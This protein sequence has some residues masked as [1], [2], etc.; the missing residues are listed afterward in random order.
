VNTT[1]ECLVGFGCF[2]QA[3][4]VGSRPNANHF[5]ISTGHL[6]GMTVIHF[7]QFRGKGW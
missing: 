3:S 2:I 7:K 4:L 5:F 1:E 6:Y